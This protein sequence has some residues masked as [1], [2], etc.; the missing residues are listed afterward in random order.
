MHAN[1]LDSLTKERTSG[2]LNIKTK[3]PSGKQNDKWNDPKV[4]KNT[5][6]PVEIR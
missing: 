1:L 4:Q 6:S 3:Q 2:D 5:K